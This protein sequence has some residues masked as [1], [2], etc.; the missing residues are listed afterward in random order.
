MNQVGDKPEEVRK[1]LEEEKREAERQQ[2]R[3]P[4]DRAAQPR[5]PEGVLSEDDVY[6]EPEDRP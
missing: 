5:E 6:E 4:G 1:R 3:K 2:E